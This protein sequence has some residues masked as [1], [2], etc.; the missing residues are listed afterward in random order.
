VATG[1]LLVTGFIGFW[2]LEHNHILAGHAAGESFLIA[3]FQS[4]TAR[5]AGF[6][7][8]AIEQL[9]GATLVFLMMLMV[10]GANPVSTGGG[11]KTVSFGILLLA[12]RAMVTRRDKVE[13]FG[14]TIPVRTLFAAL[15]VFVLYVIALGVGVF[16]LA[17]FDPQFTLRQQVFEVISALSTVGLSTG[18]T[19]EL[20]APSKIVLCLAMFIGRVGP[21]S[22]VLSIFQSRRMVTYE[23]PEEEVVVG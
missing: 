10:I 12:L 6:N 8:V 22:L 5:T 7:T 15:S 2:A 11:I 23:F 17:L 9:Q 16:L 18:I 4:V 19:A 14:R 13:A 3:A 1:V 21:I 20:S